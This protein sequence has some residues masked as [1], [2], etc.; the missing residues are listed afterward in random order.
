VRALQSANV[1]LRRG[2]RSKP[3]LYSLAGAA[4]AMVSWGGVSWLGLVPDEW[5]V[6]NR[7]FASLDNR[8]TL[9]DAIGLVVVGQPGSGGTISYR[10]LG[11]AVAITNDGYMLTSKHV[12]QGEAQG[13]IWVYLNKRRFDAR[14]VGEDSVADW[15]MLKVDDDLRYRFKMAGPGAI[16]CL[17]VPVSALGFQETIADVTSP[18]TDPPV[19]VT[20]GTVSRVYSDVVGTEW[21]EHTAALKAGSSGGPLVLDDVLVGINVGGSDGI[22]RALSVGAISA[23]IQ[24]VIKRARAKDRKTAD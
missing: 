11:T 24:K 1:T 3:A 9:T 5:R 15:A 13:K 12:L 18:L 6:F 10:S 2:L 20:Q 23:N 16:A 22:Y 14:A 19:A 21:I 17:N 4:L 7:R 8:D